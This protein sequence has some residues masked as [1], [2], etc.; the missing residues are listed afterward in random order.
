LGSAGA[1]RRPNPAQRRFAAEEGGEKSMIFALALTGNRRNAAAAIS[2]LAAVALAIA[3]VGRGC[4]VREPGPEATVRSMIAASNA[5]DRKAVFSLLTPDTQAR[6]E[7]RAQR[8]TELVGSNIRYTALDLIAIGSVEDVPAPTE[9]RVLKRD[10]PDIQP[11]KNHVIVEI[12]SAAGRSYLDV[13]KVEGKWRIDL[14]AYG[15]NP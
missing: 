9:I 12:V 7:E 11:D 15:A 4:R 2:V 13:V 8:A 14:P 5:G 6:L 3:V 10:L 1:R